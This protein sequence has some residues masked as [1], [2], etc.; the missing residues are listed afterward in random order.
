M[1]APRRLVIE[2]MRLT[3]LHPFNGLFSRTTWVSWHQKGKTSLDLN[4]AREPLSVM[5]MFISVCMLSASVD[6]SQ[7][8]IHS[9]SGLFSQFLALY[10]FVCAVCMCVF[11]VCACSNPTGWLWCACLYGLVSARQLWVDLR[12]L[13]TLWSASRRLHWP[14][15]AT[16]SQS[17]SPVLCRAHQT[18]RIFHHFETLAFWFV[19]QS[20]A[21]RYWS[22]GCNEPRFICRLRHYIKCLLAYLS[23]PLTFFLA[24]A[25]SFLSTSLRIGPLLILL[26]VL[27][28]V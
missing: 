15:S 4:D 8:T 14:R 7:M 3:T 6:Y 10:K 22:Q 17:F 2:R 13:W 1:E 19:Y 18:E 20:P 26:T 24:Y 25:L 5:V 23:S 9:A 27:K 28:N 16:H 21:A 11:G 12:L